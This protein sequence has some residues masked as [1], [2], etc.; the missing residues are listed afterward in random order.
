MAIVL[1]EE[2]VSITNSLQSDD[3]FSPFATLTGFRVNHLFIRPMKLQCNG[4]GSI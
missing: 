2:L 4:K 3:P 1:H